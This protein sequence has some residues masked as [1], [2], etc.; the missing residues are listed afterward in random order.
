[1]MNGMNL[2]ER[3]LPLASGGSLR[4]T[5]SSGRRMGLTLPT[6]EERWK[7]EEVLSVKL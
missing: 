5:V 2:L 6:K 3:R 4:D 7:V 1:M